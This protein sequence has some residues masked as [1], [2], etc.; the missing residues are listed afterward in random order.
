MFPAVFEYKVLIFVFSA[1]ASESSDE[2]GTS[3]N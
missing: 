2:R 1:A 3:L